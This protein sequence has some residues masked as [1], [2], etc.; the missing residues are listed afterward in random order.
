VT[1]IFKTPE[2]GFLRTRLFQIA[3]E[4]LQ[5]DGWTVERIPRSGK[6]SLRRLTKGKVQRIATIRTSQDAWIAFPRTSDDK[7][8]ATLSE[9]DLVVASSVDDP[10]N[11]QFAQVH[12]IEGDEMRARFDRAYAARRQA[13]HTMPIG[14]GIW[15]SLYS[16]EAA[17]P[18]SLVGAGAG[19]A[20]PP[21]ARVPLSAEE[22]VEVVEKQASQDDEEAAV[23]SPLTIAE[24]KRRLARTFGVT[25]DDVRITI[26][27]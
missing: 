26:N 22:A 5:K 10:H 23:E 27:G 3:E 12:L 8:W 18:V 4:A 7:A 11:P 24:A 14:R 25:E 15:L 2:K 1:N 19:L 13:N 20:H 6:A 21:I 9:A 16:K 17:D